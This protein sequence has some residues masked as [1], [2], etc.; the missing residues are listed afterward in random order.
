MN[1]YF[2]DIEQ[3]VIKKIKLAQSR[4]LI[5]VA[6]FT[7][8]KI[9]QELLAKNKLDIE[10]LVDD[11]KINR[12]CKN[13]SSLLANGIDVTF[14]QDLTKRY[15]LM[16]NK[17]CIIDNKFVITGSY[18]WTKSANFNDENITIL[19]DPTNAALYSH[20]FRRVKNIKFKQDSILIS[21]FD[22]TEITNLL[23]ADLLKLLRENIETLKKGLLFNWSNE[24]VK[25]KIRTI[26]ESLRNSVLDKVED[27]SL[28]REL[29]VKYGY[30][31]NTLAPEIEIAEIRD[32]LKKK[33]LEEVD[34]YLYKEY[35]FFKIKAI[36]K[37]QDNYAELL[38]TK[39]TD[40][41]KIIKIFKVFSFLSKEKADIATAI[42]IISV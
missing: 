34:S 27:Y 32:K 10:I 30:E 36:K 33:G 13:L 31:F 14:I 21:N 11:N 38:N 42:Q 41:N 19:N 16:H 35:Q 4:I 7:N 28:Y 6:W 20:E 9:G 40:K 2:Q 39:E 26:D 22:T 15:Y 25:N 23:Y 5:A 29:S 3:H 17:F 12:E 1:S 37:L 18:N 8:E 24:R